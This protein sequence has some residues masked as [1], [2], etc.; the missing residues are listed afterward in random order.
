MMFNIEVSGSLFDHIMGGGSCI[1]PSSAVGAYS[2][3][4]EIVEGT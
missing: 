4:I 2:C 1:N 3:L